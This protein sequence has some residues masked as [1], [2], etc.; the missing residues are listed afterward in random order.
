MERLKVLLASSE[1]APFAKTGGLADVAGSLPLALE[2]LGADVRVIMPRY[3]SVK[4]KG[5]D[6]GRIGRAIKVYFV[7]NDEY[8]KRDNLYG[9]AFGDYKD[10]LDRFSF[11]SREV[12]ERCRAEGFKPDIIHCNDWQTGLVP[13]YLKTIYKE[14]PFFSGTKTLFTIH[15]MAYQGLFPKEEFPRTG[16]DWELFDIDNFEFYGKVNLMKAALV[17]AD[18]I[19]TVSPTYAKE[20]ITEEFGCGLEGVLKAR[21]DS[22]H[23]IL[24]GI[25]YRVWNPETDA[26]IFKNYSAEMIDDKSANKEGLQKEAGLKIDR[27]IPIIGFI[28]RLADQ[29]GMDLIAKIIDPIL[30]MKVQFILLGTGEHKYHVLFEKIAK[31]NSKNASINLRF[32]A[33]LAEKIYAGCDLFLMPSRY[34]PCGLGQMIS[35]RYGTIPVVR[36]TGGLKDSV[37]EF[38]P[39]T[40]SGDGFTFKEYTSSS[41]LNAI[42]K[43]LEGFKEKAVW[44]ELV[45]KVMGL[46]YSWTH[47][48]KDY[49]KLYNKILKY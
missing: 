33:A 22:L 32:D 47:S 24:N 15:N 2:E 27:D 3:K 46:D 26:D 43:A 34:E 23:G 13:V 12:L 1:V 40:G 29:K 38:D 10:N 48:A 17:Y 9:D 8:F 44:H 35:F 14:D 28:S 19:S 39:K 4:A 16:L 31:K 7:K 25:D 18:A 21:E 42:K 20:I 49:L 41:L 36:E 6:E 5:G 45:K 30:N 11:F 37:H